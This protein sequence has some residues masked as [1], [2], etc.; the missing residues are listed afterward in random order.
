M[1]SSGMRPLVLP[2][3]RDRR[4]GIPAIPLPL[5]LRERCCPIGIVKAAGPGEMPRHIFD[6]GSLP[7]V[8]ASPD[9]PASPAVR[10]W[11]LS[12]WPPP[13]WQPSQD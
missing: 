8:G 11:L 7:I 3:G 5:L 12:A 10:P 1:R 9:L 13:R 2:D 4:P 6:F